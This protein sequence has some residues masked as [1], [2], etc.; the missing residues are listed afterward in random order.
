MARI[1]AIVVL[2]LL[3][4]ILML[5]LGIGMTMTGSCSS[6][7]APACAVGLAGCFAVIGS[8][9]L[10]VI[11]LRGML[12]PDSRAA[13]VPLFASRFDRPPRRP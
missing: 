1:A 2:V 6:P 12:V 13:A 3:V 10:C 5:P 9:F 11:A 8:L 4:V 7:H